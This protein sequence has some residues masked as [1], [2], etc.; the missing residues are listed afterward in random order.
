M[1]G[2]NKVL[3]YADDINL[4][5]DDTRWSEKVTN[6]QVLERTPILFNK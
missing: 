3:A 4:I 5:G 6:E 1:N 2:T